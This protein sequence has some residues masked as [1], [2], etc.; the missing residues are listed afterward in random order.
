MI[1]NEVISL[2]QVLI[3]NKKGH[4]P[5]AVLSQREKGYKIYH[6]IMVVYRD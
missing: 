3:R 1:H 5:R 4:K 6:L 2:L